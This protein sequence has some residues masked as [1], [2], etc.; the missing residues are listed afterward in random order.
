MKAE[1]KD[2]QLE[3]ADLAHQQQEMDALRAEQHKVFLVA[4]TDL[5]KGIE[6]CRRASRILRDYYGAD[7]EKADV[8]LIQSGAAEYGTDIL[9]QPAA[10]KKSSSAGAGII[11]LLEV[12]E[13]DM[14]KSLAE[15]ESEEDNSR[16][17]YEKLTQ[18]NQVI[19]TGK[20]SA[21]K[22][23]TQQFKALDKSITEITSDKATA[24]EELAA[25]NEYYKKVKRLCAPEPDNFAK[26]KTQR[27]KTDSRPRASLVRS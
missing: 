26:R 21:I 19:K 22:Y 15:A 16:D 24:H 20:D 25:V 23:K 10:Y 7:E 5:Q 2:L 6:G 9:K 18:E 27:K 3:L 13:S 12:I 1:V 11:G 14:A 8:A 4:K 17:D